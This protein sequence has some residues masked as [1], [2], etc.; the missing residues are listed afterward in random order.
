MNVARISIGG[1]ATSPSSAQHHFFMRY[2]C[3]L[4]WICRTN[5]LQPEESKIGQHSGLSR[6]CRCNDFL[7]LYVFVQARQL[8]LSEKERNTWT[9]QR[10][11]INGYTRNIDVPFSNPDRDISPVY[12][13][14]YLLFYSEDVDDLYIVK[15]AYR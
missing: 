6:M 10:F 8:L 4:Y 12:I 13:T 2:S 1:F 9:R 15:S 11:T 14:L 3:I 7:H 5:S